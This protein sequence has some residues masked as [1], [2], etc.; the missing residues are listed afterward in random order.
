MPEPTTAAVVIGTAVGYKSSRDARK[1]MEGQSEDA[2]AAEAAANAKVLAFEKKQYKDWKS[3]YG[4][5]EKNLANY[6]KKLTPG[7][8]ATQGI[9]AFQEE[10]TKELQLMEENFAQRGITTSGIAGGALM[11]EALNAAETKAGIRMDAK[12]KVLA[13]KQNFL[14]VGKGTQPNYGDALGDAADRAENFRSESVTNLNSIL[15]S[16]ARATQTLVTQ[17]GTGLAN[18]LDKPKVDTDG[19]INITAGMP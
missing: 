17:V 11:Q 15:E 1:S 7:K 2:I 10:R 5:V 4:P 18:Y 9:Q 16:E 13:M 6:Y 14:Q 12:E 19:T 8:Y 3:V